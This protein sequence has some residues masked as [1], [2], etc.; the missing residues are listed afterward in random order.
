[1]MTKLEG[2]TTDFANNGLPQLTAS[3][4]S[5]QRATDNLDQLLA[6]VRDNPRGLISQPAPKE[7]EVKP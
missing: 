3:L 7:V 4:A 5:L 1:M 2:P 6:E